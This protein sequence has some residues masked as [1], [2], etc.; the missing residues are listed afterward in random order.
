MVRK[1]GIYTPQSAQCCP[2]P[3][4]PDSLRKWRR[5]LRVRAASCWLVLKSS[6]TNGRQGV[7]RPISAP[8]AESGVGSSRV[9]F[10]KDARSVIQ[11]PTILDVPNGNRT[12]LEAGFLEVFEVCRA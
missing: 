12:G 9:I 3:S 4:C 8:R 7:G 10:H 11:H 1:G 2:T 6:W 5:S